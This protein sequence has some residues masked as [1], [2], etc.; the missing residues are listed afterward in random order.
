MEFAL[1][2]L[3]VLANVSS[4]SIRDPI[5]IYFF[6]AL[7]L[8]YVYAKFRAAAKALELLQKQWEAAESKHTDFITI[9][10]DKLAS[11]S[12]PAS[13]VRLS[14][15]G[16]IRLQPDMRTEIVAMAKRGVSADDIARTVGLKEG[17]IEVVLGI[18]RLK[19]QAKTAR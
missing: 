11:L 19:R 14:A 6:L 7:T 18:A 13:V 2:K 1:Q 3:L 9:A 15:A 5:L 8:L 10:R 12:Q 4:I 16:T 17:E